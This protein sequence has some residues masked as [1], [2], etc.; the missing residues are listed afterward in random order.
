MNRAHLVTLHA[1]M[2]AL[3]A[4]PPSMLDEIARW[5]APAKPNGHDP[6]PPN[7]KALAS[8]AVAPIDAAGRQDPPRPGRGKDR[9]AQ[10]H[11]RD[12]SQPRIIH[13]RAG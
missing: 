4:L 10:A 2:S 7:G 1:A 11:R 9:R 3:L 12:A 8:I 5:L 6:H 13:R